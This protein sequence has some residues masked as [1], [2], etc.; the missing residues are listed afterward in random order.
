M[1]SYMIEAKTK[2]KEFCSKINIECEVKIEH[3]RKE[4]AFYITVEPSKEVYNLSA[5]LSTQVFIAFHKADDEFSW[6]MY[7]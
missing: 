3:V 7:Y 4:R 5:M 1:Q 2:A 6:L